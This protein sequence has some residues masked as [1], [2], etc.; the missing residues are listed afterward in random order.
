MSPDFVQVAEVSQAQIDQLLSREITL[1]DALTLPSENR[2]WLHATTGIA[3][4]AVDFSQ[5]P[6]SSVQYQMQIGIY[7]YQG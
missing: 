3:G 7:D 2:W 1:R 6:L 5:P 4:L